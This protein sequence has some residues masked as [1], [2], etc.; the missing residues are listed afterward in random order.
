MPTYYAG[1]QGVKHI[2][3][4]PNCKNTIHAYE[5]T[6]K[7]RKYKLGIICP[8][9]DASLEM[10]DPSKYSWV[11]LLKAALFPLLLIFGGVAEQILS[12]PQKRMLAVILLVIFLVWL[13]WL[14]R[15]IYNHVKL[16]VIELG[17]RNA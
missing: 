16:R 1:E 8:A 4:C 10:G 9:C 13:G 12:A 15:A 5:K 2:M 3:K 17:N 7:I 11:F 6:K 14:C